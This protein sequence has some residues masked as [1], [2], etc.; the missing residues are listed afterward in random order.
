[1]KSLFKKIR[2]KDDNPRSPRSSK[3]GGRFSSADNLT[4][5]M[6]SPSSP[7][8]AQLSTQTR[9]VW[10]TRRGSDKGRDV[11]IFTT[12]P[13]PD[14]ATPPHTGLQHY[15]ALREEVHKA[16]LGPASLREPAALTADAYHRHKTLL[17]PHILTYISGQTSATETQLVTEMAVPLRSRISAQ[18]ITLDELCLGVVGIARALVW[19]HA[20]CRMA[21]NNVTLDGVFVTQAGQGVPCRWCLGDFSL[22]CPR[23]AED[24]VEHSMAYQLVVAPEDVFEAEGRGGRGRARSFD[25]ASRDVY[26]LG[27]LIDEIISSS[28]LG[29]A[30]AN[31]VRRDLMGKLLEEVDSTECLGA[32]MSNTQKSVGSS[33]RMEDKLADR[34]LEALLGE[35][36]AAIE[37]VDPASLRPVMLVSRVPDVRP[38]DTAEEVALWSLA[39]MH[40]SPTVRPLLDD[41]VE[42]RHILGNLLVKAVLFLSE[43]RLFADERQKAAGYNCVL[44]AFER[45]VYS[46]VVEFVA[47]LV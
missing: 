36:A 25:L 28:G 22:A 47:P 7:Q 20:E 30:S 17:H 4:D 46:D 3:L 31:D 44:Q 9:G 13:H 33:G 27:C 40:R 6:S 2:S 14:L 19:L 23:D 11:L 29:M 41:L 10:A 32:T 37:W 26:A 43:E 16:L 34:G 38:L 24:M 45:C 15:H 8:R 5:Q 39:A 1:M 21:Y 42:G 12:S 35:V 18:N